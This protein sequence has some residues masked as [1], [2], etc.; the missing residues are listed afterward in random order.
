MKQLVKQTNEYTITETTGLATVD[1]FFYLRFAWQPSEA[2]GFCEPYT[3]AS[4]GQSLEQIL[5]YADEH[6]VGET[7]PFLGLTH[8]ELRAKIKVMLNGKHVP[9]I[10]SI[11]KWEQD[12]RG[13]AGVAIDH[14]MFWRSR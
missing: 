5:K 12:E 3:E 7:N 1:G 2:D 11:Q 10:V 8:E 9:R 14:Y 13:V 6:S 4:R